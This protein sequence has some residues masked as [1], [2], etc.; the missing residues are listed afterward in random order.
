MERFYSGKRSSRRGSWCLNHSAFLS[1]SSLAPPQTVLSGPLWQQG[2]FP[3]QFQSP[4]LPRN[5]ITGKEEKVYWTGSLILKIS[6]RCLPSRKSFFVF[7]RFYLFI[8]E[9]HTERGRD[10]GSGRSRLP[11]G[12]P[13][14]DSIPGPWDHNLSQRQTLNHWATQAPHCVLLINGK[15]IHFPSHVCT[16]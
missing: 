15:P 14:W 10:I 3:S 13:R 8:H 1:M 5:L 11:E 7:Q 9:R 4:V 16:L 6:S 2:D 12:S